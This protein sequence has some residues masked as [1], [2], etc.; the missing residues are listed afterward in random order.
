MLGIGFDSG[1][2]HTSVV[3]DRGRGPEM[4]QSNESGVSISNARG[5]RTLSAAAE[6]IT[7]VISQHLDDDICAWIGAAGFSASTANTIAEAFA[8]PM[9]QLRQQLQQHNDRR[10]LFLW[11]D[12]V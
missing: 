7:D 5:H 12:A 8:A 3:L 1:G 6:W 2:T 11:N 10:D 9:N 4:A